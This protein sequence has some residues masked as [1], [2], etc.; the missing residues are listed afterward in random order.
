MSKILALCFSRILVLQ[1]QPDGTLC[2]SYTRATNSAYWKHTIKKLVVR[3]TVYIDVTV[4]KMTK[5]PV[6]QRSVYLQ[7]D[8]QKV[9]K[10]KVIYVRYM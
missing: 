5:N 2:E 10:K 6:G 7:G 4:W 9:T 8:P 1:S 3:L